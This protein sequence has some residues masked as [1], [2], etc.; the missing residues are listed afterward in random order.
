MKAEFIDLPGQGMVPYYTSSGAARR[1]DLTPA[2]LLGLAVRGKLPVV[3]TADRRLRLYPVVAVE[4]LRRE[5]EA[6]RQ[7]GPEPAA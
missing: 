4:K 6:A 5:R 2:G 3:R 7:R 1:L